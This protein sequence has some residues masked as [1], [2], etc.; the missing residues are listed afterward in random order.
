MKTSIIF[1]SALLAS[2]SMALPYTSLERRKTSEQIVFNSINTWIG[3]INT[4]NKF[5]DNPSLDPNVALASAQNKPNQLQIL[6]SFN[7]DANRQNAATL[8]S[9]VFGNVVTALQ[10]I[11]NNPNGPGVQV[12]LQEINNV[13]CLNVLLAVTTLW[14]SAASAVGA[15]PP[16]AANIPSVCSTMSQ[17]IP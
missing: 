12:D 17:T 7:L 6:S 13:C 3:N 2:S 9:E 15:P 11:V 10:D 1:L 4:V 14:A 16:P 8:L 5:V